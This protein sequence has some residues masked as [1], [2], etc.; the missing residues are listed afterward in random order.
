MLA[1][2]VGRRV[3]LNTCAEGSGIAT[4]RVESVERALS[5]LE[6]FSDGPAGLSLAEIAHRSGL[7]PSTILRLAGSLTTFGYLTRD[8]DGIFRLG[9]SLWRLGSRYQASFDLATYVRPVLHDLVEAT[10]E[11]SAFYIKSGGRRVCLYREHAPRSLRH[12]VEE[13]AELPLDRGASARILMAYTGEPG[14]VYDTIRHQGFYVSIGER[15]P[16]TAA[17]AVPVFGQRH[18]FVGAL[19]ITGSLARMTDDRIAEIRSVLVT[20][21]KALSSTLGAR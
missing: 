15:D 11:T 2:Q 16:E 6:T 8:H 1:A 14:Q 5:I 9:P 13:G 20:E 7:Y 12:H 19:G 18:E 3:R 17:V 21:S 4:Q 10:G